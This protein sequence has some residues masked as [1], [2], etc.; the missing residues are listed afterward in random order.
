ME[1]PLLVLMAFSFTFL[2]KNVCS[3]ILQLLKE[4]A[5]ERKELQSKNCQ[6]EEW[7]F[8]HCDTMSVA[9]LRASL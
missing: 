8:N 7:Q 5:M 6:S 2:N 4:N 3:Y 9:H 1:L